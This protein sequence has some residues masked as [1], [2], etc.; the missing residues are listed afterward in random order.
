M[1]ETMKTILER[2]S[3]RSFSS[4]PVAEEILKDL[5]DAAMHAP[6]GMCR[7][8]WKFTVVMNQEIIKRLAKVIEK[9]LDR[10]GYDMYNPVAL[11]IPSNER[12]SKYG[13]EDNACALQNIFLAAE[14]YGVGSVWINQLTGICDTPE[15]REILNE[16]E[17]P[18]NH[19]VYGIAAL[20]FANPNATK[21][22]YR[23]IGEVKI[24]R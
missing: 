21:P 4:G 22:A 7:K 18:E 17:I 19:I 9:V 10:P 3:V 1:N 13:R 24:I 8:T 5:A 15:V 16:M 6:S 11:I 23:E 20:G 2:R 14:S 12:D